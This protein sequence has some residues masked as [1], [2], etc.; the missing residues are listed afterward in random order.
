[1]SLSSCLHYCYLIL[2]WPPFYRKNFFFSRI[3]FLELGAFLDLLQ[4]CHFVFI[5]YSLTY[6]VLAFRGLAELLAFFYLSDWSSFSVRLA[7]M[8]LLLGWV[9]LRF[10]RLFPKNF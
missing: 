4:I 1:M 7:N 6:L 5:A 2:A 8:P 3:C 9:A 10:A